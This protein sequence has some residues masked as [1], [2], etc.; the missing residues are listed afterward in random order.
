MLLIPKNANSSL[1]NSLLMK[2]E[3]HTLK[4]LI[5]KKKWLKTLLLES[6]KS[7]KGAKNY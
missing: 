3:R 7:K 4:A 6:C 5:V 2:K 1:S